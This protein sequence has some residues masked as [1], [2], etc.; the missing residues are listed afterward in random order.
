MCRKI[1]TPTT[2]AGCRT[3]RTR[4]RGSEVD[5]GHR[6][7]RPTDPARLRWPMSGRTRPT[8]R[9]CFDWPRAARRKILG[10]DA[11]DRPTQLGLAG[12]WRPSTP[13]R[14]VFNV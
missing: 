11:S 7:H 3:T 12:S 9:P 4:V 6:R 8:D 10:S 13:L 5:F 2:R 1:P 14:K